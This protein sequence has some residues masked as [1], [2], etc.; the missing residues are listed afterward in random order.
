MGQ[1]PCAMLS[2]DHVSHAMTLTTA[3]VGHPCQ[4]TVIYPYYTLAIF[5]A[6]AVRTSMNKN[7]GNYKMI[8]VVHVLNCLWLVIIQTVMPWAFFGFLLNLYKRGH[9][10]LT[11]LLESSLLGC[12]VAAPTLDEESPTC[13]E[14]KLA[15]SLQTAHCVIDEIFR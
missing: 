13:L 5:L 7:D 15:T 12:S 2:P 11:L 1:S 4:F 3:K 6:A 9:Q 10:S 8:P 14:K